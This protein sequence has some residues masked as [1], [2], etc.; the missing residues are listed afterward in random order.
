MQ[1]ASGGSTLAHLRNSQGASVAGVWWGRGRGWDMRLEVTWAR[2]HR[3]END[4]KRLERSD[5]KMF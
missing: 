4:E 1:R 3:P 5:R 2:S